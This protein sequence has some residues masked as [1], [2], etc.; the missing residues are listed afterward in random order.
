ME[1]CAICEELFEEDELTDTTGMLNGG[2][3]YVCEQ[4]LEDNDIGG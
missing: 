4:C 3:G 1:Q 2:V